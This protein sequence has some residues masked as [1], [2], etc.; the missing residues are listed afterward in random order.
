VPPR[1]VGLGRVTFVNYSDLAQTLREPREIGLCHE[2][3]TD[4]QP[5]QSP[6]A[7]L[8]SIQRRNFSVYSI[9]L[10]QNSAVSLQVGAV[11]TTIPPTR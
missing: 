11:S 10:P 9:M 7:G 6:R 2:T 8:P 4:C 3:L 1:S 5:S